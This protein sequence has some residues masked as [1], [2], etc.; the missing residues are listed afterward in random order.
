M[1]IKECPYHPSKVTRIIGRQATNLRK[2]MDG[3]VVIR[4]PQDAL[5]HQE[6]GAPSLLDLHVMSKGDEAPS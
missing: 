4:I 1:Y 6:H 2:E 3:E 5:L